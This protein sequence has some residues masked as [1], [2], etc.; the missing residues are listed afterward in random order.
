MPSKGNPVVHT[1]LSRELYAAIEEQ[2]ARCRIN[3][4]DGPK[5]PAEFLRR[6]AREKLAK[7][8]RSRRPRGQAARRPDY[9]T[10]TGV[11]TGQAEAVESEVP[12]GG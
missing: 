10:E 11:D 1:R 2:I 3:G 12:S 6:A 4:R 5:D 9:T 8:R 7:M